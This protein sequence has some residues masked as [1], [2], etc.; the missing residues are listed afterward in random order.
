MRQV[1]RLGGEREDVL[2]DLVCTGRPVDGRDARPA[3]RRREGCSGWELSIS[4]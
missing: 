3:V 2:T 1:M 4:D